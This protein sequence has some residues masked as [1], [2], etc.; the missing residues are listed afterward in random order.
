MR[1][2]ATAEVGYADLMRTPE[3]KCEEVAERKKER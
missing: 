1:E 3:I 2:I